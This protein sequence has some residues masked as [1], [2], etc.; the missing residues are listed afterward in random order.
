M[1]VLEKI[2]TAVKEDPGR[3]AFMSVSGT[4]TYEELLGKVRKAG[5]VYR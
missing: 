2:F 4:L 1:S 3:T 5:V